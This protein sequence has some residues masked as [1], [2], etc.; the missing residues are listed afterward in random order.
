MHFHRSNEKEMNWNVILLH[1]LTPTRTCIQNWIYRR[2]NWRF[3]C[4]KW[5]WCEFFCIWTVVVYRYRMSTAC[6][7]LA[8]RLSNFFLRRDFNWRNKFLR[9]KTPRIFWNTYEKNQSIVDSKTLGFVQST[10]KRKTKQ[11]CFDM[12]GYRAIVFSL[13]HHSEK[14]MIECITNVTTATSNFSHSVWIV[15]CIVEIFE[16]I[17]SKHKKILIEM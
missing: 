7:F 4:S 10:H 14:R 2:E 3:F 1:A 17:I 16:S 9:S 12:N 5:N 6:S 11:F 15:N 13:S 8:L